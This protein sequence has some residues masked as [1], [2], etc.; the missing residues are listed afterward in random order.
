MPEKFTIVHVPDDAGQAIEAMGS[1]PKFWYGDAAMGSCLYKQA[2]PG[3][4]EDWAEKV[5]A[6]LAELLG[7][8]HARVELAAWRDT[9]GTVSPSFV[10]KGD[11]LIHGN[12]ILLQVVPGYPAAQSATRNFMRIRQHTL[13]AVLNVVGTDA[14][15]P[16]HEWTPITGISSAAGVFL[17]YLMLDAWIGNTDRHH[18]NWAIVAR[19]SKGSPG[20]MTFHLAPTYDHASCLGRNESDERRRQRLATKDATFSV[21]AYV[22]KS[23]SALYASEGDS[24]PMATFDAFARAAMLHPSAAAAWLVRL[25]AVEA[26]NTQLVFDCLPKERISAPASAFAHEMLMLNR[27]RL[28]ALKGVLP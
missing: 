5:A 6:E 10:S 1:K 14:V 13:A 27:D 2:R 24:K 28:L 23:R 21:K 11:A 12:E 8:P 15:L 3:T 16:P 9:C 20:Q 22:E 18:E 26:E 17:G 4:G 19:L 7:L 25:A